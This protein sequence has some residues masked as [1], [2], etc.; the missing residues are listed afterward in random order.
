MVVPPTLEK[1]V[2][3]IVEIER[4]REVERL[5]QVPVTTE[6]FVEIEMIKNIYHETE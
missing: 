2:N 1:L 4:I 3:R 5:V 6:K